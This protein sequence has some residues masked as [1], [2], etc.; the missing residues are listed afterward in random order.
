MK[1]LLK[2]PIRAI[3]EPFGTAGLI[4]AMIAL[5]AALGGTA[6]AAAKLNSTQKKEVEKIAKKFAG[7]PG[8]TGPQG[9]PGAPG[10]AGKDGANGSNGSNG[11]SVT[12]KPIAAGPTCAAGGTEF[13]SA[14]GT[15]H[16]CNGKPGTTGFT[17]TLPSGKTE[18]G[19]IFM[20]S[21]ALINLASFNIPLASALE[22]SHVV[23]LKAAEPTA[24]HCPGVAA[25][26]PAEAGY[27]CVYVELESS[28]GEGTM[29]IVGRGL[30]NEG[31]DGVILVGNGTGTEPFLNGTWAV[32]AP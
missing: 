19:V 18:T 10:A 12:S 14:S 6:F 1:R 26:P 15:E 31:K 23:I 11:S 16:V 5:L 17:E 28:G 20:S 24:T 30:P 32:T 29:E 13:T 8:A 9:S 4:V 7:K 2:H 27:M 3:R 22:A 21:S 25:E